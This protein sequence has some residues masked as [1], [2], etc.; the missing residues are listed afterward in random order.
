[1]V[2]AVAVAVAAVVGAAL[3]AV[4]AVRPGRRVAHPRGS[5]DAG[6]AVAA[7]G[8][9]SSSSSSS[10]SSC[11]PNPACL[12]ARSAQDP[13]VARTG[14]RAG[15][16]ALIDLSPEYAHPVTPWREWPRTGHGATAEES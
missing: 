5:P 4:G 14:G 8:L 9:D 12:T 3:I 10:C 15:A 16:G 2:V 1:M 6:P 7:T 13:A 11:F